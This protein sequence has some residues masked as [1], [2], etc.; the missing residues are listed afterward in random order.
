M[1]NEVKT[2]P[3]SP[4]N[5][6]VTKFDSGYNFAVFAKDVKSV[7]LLIFLSAEDEPDYMFE[8]HPSINKT[9]DVW[10]IELRGI[11]EPFRYGYRTKGIKKSLQGPKFDDQIILLDT[12]A[13][14]VSGLEI[15]NVRDSK[16]K[17][18]GYYQT[19][20]FDWE[21]D[22][23]IN[24]PLNE[25]IIYEMHVRGFTKDSSSDVQ[26]PGTYQGLIEKIDYLK[27]L[28][29]TAVELLP[30]HEFDETDCK[31]INPITGE[32]LLNYWG[33]STLNYFAVKSGYST[34][35]NNPDA[36]NEF[37]E[38]VKALHKADIEVIL[39]VV[40]NHTAEG[41]DDRPVFNFKGFGKDVYYQLDQ[42]GDF[43]N[44]SGCGNTLN[45]NNSAVADMIIQSLRYFVVDMHVDGFRFDLASVLTRNEYGEPMSCPPIVKMI[46]EDPILS[47]TKIIAEPW[48]PAGL[49]QVGGFPAFGRWAEW[50]AIYRDLIRKVS[51]GEPGHMAELATRIA[52]SEDLYKGSD[53]KPYHS[54][55]FITAHDGFSLMDLVSYNE[56]HN[57][58]NGEGNKDGTDINYSQ[59]FGVE[60][61]TNDSKIIK[62]RQK[63]MRNMAT[64]LLLSQGTPMILA[65][66]EFGNSQEGNNNAWCQDNEVSW[67]N[68]NLLKE[69]REL[70]L[71][72][73]NLIKFR[74]QHATLRRKDFFKG[75]TNPYSGLQ[76]ISWHN[77]QSDKPDFDSSSR[78][79]AFLIDGMEGKKIICDHIYVAINF[80]QQEKQFQLPTISKGGHWK[81]ILD[82]ENPS[83]FIK[84]R[85]TRF[86][87]DQ[88]SVEVA[89]RSIIVLTKSCE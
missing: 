70:F 61:I 69:N 6:G 23:P 59:N 72:W 66:D 67:L 85:A 25:T 34:S 56:K 51:M 60:G 21:G 57:Y 76:D 2:S 53:R 73:K 4:L 30:I 18:L 81:F 78:S 26:N 10:H 62:E 41:G 31:Y 58:Q 49:F 20:E 39:D 12:F 64:L 63:C 9:G 52:G 46:A 11:V 38:M 43:L 47:K 8:L 82:T 75:T 89:A 15:W 65:G 48:D 68:W 83:D 79:L 54:V 86:K 3:G 87:N 36:R 40:F 33:Y 29:V 16:K 14:A 42:A 88:N 24:R 22:K 28:G 45:G 37:R 80:D 55:N 5:L 32:R 1:L 71:F 77:T 50:N 13:K 44:L 17:L 19:L 84:G 27:E 35:Q 74:K 7:D